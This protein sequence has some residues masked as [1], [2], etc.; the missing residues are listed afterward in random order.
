MRDRGHGHQDDQSSDGRIIV[1]NTFSRERELI[2]ELLQLFKREKGGNW[3]FSWK[4]E[5]IHQ[6]LS[7]SLSSPYFTRAQNVINNWRW[8]MIGLKQG[9]VGRRKTFSEKWQIRQTS[10]VK[11][12]GARLGTFVKICLRIKTESGGNY[13]CSLFF[14]R[15]VLQT[16]IGLWIVW[17]WEPAL[18]LVYIVVKC[19]VFCST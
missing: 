9:K 6:M 2:M 17:A 15:L 3:E 8:H 5:N 19:S 16:I 1:T 14:Y 7:C 18:I 10:P 13:L 4:M 12:M 11:I